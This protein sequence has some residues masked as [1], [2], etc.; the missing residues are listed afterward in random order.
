MSTDNV[1]VARRAYETLARGDI[2][3]FFATLGPDI[4]WTHPKGLPYGGTH[5]GLAEMQALA[6][7]WM[8][9]YEEMRVEPEEFLD[10]G[11]TVVVIGRYH[12]RPRGAEALDTW[13][14]NVF[15]L[16][17]GRI[18]RFRDFSDKAARLEPVFKALVSA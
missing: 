11:D 6:G 12:V 9:L 8:E 3:G 15:D 14:V 4:E 16:A 2:E 13:F 10:A 18:V 5:R 17:D 7:R 1:A